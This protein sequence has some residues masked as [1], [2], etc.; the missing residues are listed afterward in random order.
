MVQLML[1]IAK[2][3]WGAI[4]LSTPH[5][6][7]GAVSMSWWYYQW[8]YEWMQTPKSPIKAGF[9]DPAPGHHLTSE[10][11]VIHTVFTRLG[12]E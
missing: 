2:R 4:L 11:Y 1:L 12:L 6:F 9:F 10:G 3:G 5:E 7:S 8:S